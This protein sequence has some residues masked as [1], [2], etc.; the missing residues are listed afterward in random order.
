LS[1]FAQPQSKCVIVP[2]SRSD[3]LFFRTRGKYGEGEKE[4]RFPYVLAL[5]FSM[6]A[7]NYVFAW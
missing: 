7:V 1:S 2:I 6:C 3:A 4:E 5:V